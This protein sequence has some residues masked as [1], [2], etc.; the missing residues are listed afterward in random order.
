MD[1][2]HLQKLDIKDKTARYSFY[3]IRD[4]PT[5]ILRPANE[6]NKQY[7]NAVLSKSRKNVRA[8]QAGH[9]N[10]SMIAESRNKDRELY[11]SFVVVGWE[12]VVDSQGEEVPFS[13]EACRDFLNALPDWLFDELRTFAAKSSNFAEDRVDAGEVAGN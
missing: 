10:Q 4:E 1:F 13:S 3:Q 11:P 6:A 7:F 8:I 9:V 5:L 12:N 2:S